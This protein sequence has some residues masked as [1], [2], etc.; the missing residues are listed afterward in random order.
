MIVLD[1]DRKK[2]R[3]TKLDDNPGFVRY[4]PVVSSM[5]GIVNM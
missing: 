2:I 1:V 3:D 5:D 4:S